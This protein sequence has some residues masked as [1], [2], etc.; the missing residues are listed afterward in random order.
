M[1]ARVLALILGRH[2]WA[3]ALAMM[4]AGLWLPG[5]WTGLRPLVPVLLGGILFFTGLKVRVGA[6][7]DELRGAQRLRR[8]G[9]LT[10]LKLVA[11]P[12][13]AWAIARVIAPEWALGV[14][15]VTAM[16]AGLSAAAVT[17]LYRGNVALALV[18]TFVTS[19]LCPLSVPLLLQ[20]L[21]PRAGAVDPWLLAER[22]LYIIVLLVV[23]FSLAQVV[24]RIA[25]Q[26]VARHFHRWTY[27]AILSSCLLIFVSI[28]AN[29]AAWA[30]MAPA[31]LLVPLGLNALAMALGLAVGLGSRRV[32][33]P[34]DGAAFAFC[35][36]WMNNGLGVAF[37]DRFFHGQA[38]VILGPVLMQL[39][40]IA[41]VSFLGWWTRR[42][43]DPE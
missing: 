19:A 5:D 32:L 10:A 27:G 17:D 39:P 28:S 13:A 6:V 29:R 22:A 3:L 38:G 11:L 18:L 12:L 21:D 33:P 43:Q 7:V 31:L 26:T 36:A 23:P 24:R 9:A 15:L 16:P 41:G 37:A 14:L 20:A 1:L 35:C 34:A 8:L 25:P 2:F 42:D 4:A 30:G 40:I